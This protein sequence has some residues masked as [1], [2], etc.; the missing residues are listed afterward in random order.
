V[1]GPRSELHV[2]WKNTK[3]RTS[4][5]IPISERLKPVLARRRFNLSGSPMS[6]DAFVFG[7]SVGE[8]L[9]HHTHSW[10]TRRF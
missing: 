1:W 10:W 6:L 4:R 9:A 2:P 8:R 3:T 7:N 5:R